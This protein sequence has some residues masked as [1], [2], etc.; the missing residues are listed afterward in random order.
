MVS[1]R[2]LC[3]FHPNQSKKCTASVTITMRLGAGGG[4]FLPFSC[5]NRSKI[6]CFPWFSIANG[7]LIYG[8]RQAYAAVLENCDAV[9][10]SIAS[11]KLK[12]Y[13]I[14]SNILKSRIHFNTLKKHIV[15]IGIF[16]PRHRGGTSIDHA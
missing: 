15:P 16:S 9:T 4:H 3:G 5:G 10:T 8:F 13:Y 2:I 14:P 6:R 1:K 7:V 12:V 11:N